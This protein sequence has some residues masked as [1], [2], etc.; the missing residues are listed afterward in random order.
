M[1]VVLGPAEISDEDRI[2]IGEDFVGLGVFCCIMSPY[3]ITEDPNIITIEDYDGEPYSCVFSITN[4][5][6]ILPEITGEFLILHDGIG[7]EEH[8]MFVLEKQP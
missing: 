3:Q 6:P 1:Q 5:H 8:N 2:E 7:T 4:I